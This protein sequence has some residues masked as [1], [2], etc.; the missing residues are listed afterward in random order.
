VFS[1]GPHARRSAT[2]SGAVNV[3]LHELEH[4]QEAADSPVAV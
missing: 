4:D 3:M 1:G 2:A